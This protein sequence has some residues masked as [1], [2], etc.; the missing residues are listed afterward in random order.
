M[1]KDKYYKLLTLIFLALRHYL[2]FYF[3]LGFFIRIGLS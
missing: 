2:A 3:A 1:R